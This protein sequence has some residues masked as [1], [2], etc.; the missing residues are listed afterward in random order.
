MS[1]TI[2]LGSFKWSHLLI[3]KDKSNKLLDLHPH[4]DDG[5]VHVVGGLLYDESGRIYLHHD[6][7]KNEFLLPGG[8]VE[9]EESYEEALTRELKEELDI[10]ILSWKYLSSVKYIWGG[11]RRCFHMFEIDDYSG[12]PINNES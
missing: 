9:L 7:R 12:I 8:K 3:D 10:D 6:A 5:F 2:S 1:S 11:V 4:T